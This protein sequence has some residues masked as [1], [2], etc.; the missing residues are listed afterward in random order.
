MT[1]RISFIFIRA[2]RDQI[3]IYAQINLFEIS[4]VMIQ[5]QLNSVYVF[6]IR[7]QKLLTRTLT[8]RNPLKGVN[9]SQN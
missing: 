8:S 4:S 6:S 7:N 2:Y 9:P 1:S 3:L 5:F